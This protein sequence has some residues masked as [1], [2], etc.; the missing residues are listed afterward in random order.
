MAEVRSAASIFLK[1]MSKTRR[2]ISSTLLM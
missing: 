1:P 2:T